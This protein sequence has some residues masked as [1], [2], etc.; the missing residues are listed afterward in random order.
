MSQE[1]LKIPTTITRTTPHHLSQRNILRTITRQHPP[2]K[3]PTITSSITPPHFSFTAPITS[4][5]PPC[6]YFADPRH[7]TNAENRDDFF[8]ENILSPDVTLPRAQH[9]HTDRQHKDKYLHPAR[10]INSCLLS[11]YLVKKKQ[12]SLRL[13]LAH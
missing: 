4:S 2:K 13:F 7:G 11:I 5:I 6:K 8:G 1:T 12:M 9:T 10:F 3:P